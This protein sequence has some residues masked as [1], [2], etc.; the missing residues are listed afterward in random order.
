MKCRKCEAQLPLKAVFCH[1]CGTRQKALNT[2]GGRKSRPGGQ[3]T[4]Y[5]RGKTYTA[6]IT[7]SIAGVRQSKSKGG[8]KTRSDALDYMPELKKAIGLGAGDDT[9]RVITFCDLYD[10]WSD[11]KYNGRLGRVIGKSTII[12]YKIAYKRC[13]PLY[14]FQDFRKIHYPDMQLVVDSLASY[15]TQ[16]DVR[17]LLSQMS[18]YAMKMEYCEM[19]YA[20]LLD[21]INYR[22]PEKDAFTDEEVAALWRDYK[23]VDREGNATQP[24]PFTGFILIMIECGLRYGELS[25]I[26]KENVFFDERYMLG[27][28][29]SVI[30]RNTPIAI[31]DVILPVIKEKYDA[32]RTKLLHMNEDNFYNAYYATCERVGVRPL[33]PHCCRH[34]FITRLS[35]N[36]APLFVVQ[37]GARHAD[38]KTTQGY[39]HMNIDD[40]INAVNSLPN[41][42]E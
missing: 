37:K 3:G 28:I 25:T 27:G 22:S 8:F 2:N 17:E 35:R 11:K 33:N 40:V 38:I 4:V 32:G 30:S 13:E 29:K 14:V 1:L 42:S 18:K 16:K 36:G 5:K 21:V 41:L 26:K 31:S 12:A 10:E 34:T 23:G 9:R 15:D 19:N 20:A 7:K 24:H 6:R 39:T